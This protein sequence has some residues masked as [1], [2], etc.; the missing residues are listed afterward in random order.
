MWSDIQ[1]NRLYSSVLNTPFIPLVQNNQ[2]QYGIPSNSYGIPSNSCGIQSIPVNPNP[3]EPKKKRSNY[4]YTCKPR[5]KV[6]KH[7]IEKSELKNVVFHFDMHK[8]P[9]IL[10]TPLYHYTNVFEI[11]AN[12]LKDIYNSIRLFCE[13]WNIKNYQLSFNNGEWQTHSHFHIKIK[14]PEKIVT[15]MKKDHFKMHKLNDQYCGR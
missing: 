6:L 8:R 7:I 2:P 15:R 1:D 9:V 10:V 5:G 11:P 13:E 12:E 14:C 4:C 3:T